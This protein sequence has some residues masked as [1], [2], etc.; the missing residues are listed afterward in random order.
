MDTQEF[1]RV[2]LVRKRKKEQA[3]EEKPVAK[4]KPVSKP[5]F[6]LVLISRKS[7]RRLLRTGFNAIYRAYADAY[8]ND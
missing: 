2:E 7:G 4:R 5:V 8:G 1:S 6:L 3:K